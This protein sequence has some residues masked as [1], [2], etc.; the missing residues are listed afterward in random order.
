[1]PC[2]WD[3]LT[4]LPGSIAILKLTC[5]TRTFGGCRSRGWQGQGWRPFDHLNFLR[6][7]QY[8]FCSKRCFLTRLIAKGSHRLSHNLRLIFVYLDWLKNYCSELSQTHRLWHSSRHH[9]EVLLYLVWNQRTNWWLG[10]SM[11]R[12]SSR[13]NYR[14]S[15]YTASKRWYGR[16]DPCWESGKSSVCL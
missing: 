14:R 8:F 16:S 15:L 10:S 7:Y 2:L 4:I 5:H 1:M 11:S 13:I 3:N 12:V 9:W 6:P